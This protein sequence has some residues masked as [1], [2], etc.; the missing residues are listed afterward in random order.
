MREPLIITMRKLPA[1]NWTGAAVAGGEIHVDAGAKRSL[2]LRAIP[3][4]HETTHRRKTDA[5]IVN[6]GPR[7]ALVHVTA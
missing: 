2:A 5:R 6:P 7:S 4:R 1:S 3:W